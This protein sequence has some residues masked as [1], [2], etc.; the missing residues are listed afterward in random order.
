M[1]KIRYRSGGEENV[2]GIVVRT[3]AMGVG[4]GG[5]YHSQTGE[6]IFAGQAGLKVVIPR[7]PI[8]AKGLFLASVED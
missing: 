6:S 7:D 2:G 5:C 1:A 8:T 4:H 3:A